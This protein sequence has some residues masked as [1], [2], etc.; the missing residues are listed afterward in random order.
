MANGIPVTDTIRL[1]LIIFSRL[2]FVEQG[3]L[4]E[5]CY[6]TDARRAINSVSRPHPALFHTLEG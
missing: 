6:L 3:R 2:H 4:T 5:Y 1:A